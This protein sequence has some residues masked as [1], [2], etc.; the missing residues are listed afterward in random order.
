MAISLR[1]LRCSMHTR[2]APLRSAATRQQL[3]QV[4]AHGILDSYRQQL[5]QKQGTA[6][7]G[8]SAQTTVSL[9]SSEQDESP[10]VES[11]LLEEGIHFTEEDTPCP[12]DCVL[13]VYTEEEIDTIFQ[14][15][16]P[17]ALVVVDWYKTDCPACKYMAPGFH[18]MCRSASEH[19]QHIIFVKHNVYDDDDELTALARRMKIK[20]VPLFTFHKNN[21]EVVDSFATRD[22]ARLIEAVNKHAPVTVEH[23]EDE[24]M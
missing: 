13:Q 17:D 10:V 3:R 22:K 5:Q 8:G 14:S 18:R 7:P 11:I 23:W 4:V 24:D 15:A 2:A 12:T 19:A 21:G 1:A 16:L 9:S 6:S 20:N